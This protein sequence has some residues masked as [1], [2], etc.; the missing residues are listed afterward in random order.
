MN[1]DIRA[2]KVLS[3]DINKGDF[4]L[5]FCD[6]EFHYRGVVKQET[7]IILNVQYVDYS[8]TS[9]NSSSKVHRHP[10]KLCSTFVMSVHCSLN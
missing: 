3:E 8:N 6:N 1:G 9:V 5:Y 10:Q 7:S 2:F 4:S